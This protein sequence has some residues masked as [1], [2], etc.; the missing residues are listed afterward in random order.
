MTKLNILKIKSYDKII[1]IINKSLKR[2]RSINDI[3]YLR[4][5]NETINIQFYIEASR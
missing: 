1:Y 4:T 2:R 5:T 3:H